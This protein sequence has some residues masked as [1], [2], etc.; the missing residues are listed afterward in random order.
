MM[1]DRSAAVLPRAAGEGNRAQR[2]AGGPAVHRRH[3]R[4]DSGSAILPRAAAEDGRG[5]L[6]IGASRA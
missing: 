6:V 2:G 3:R 4:V 5:G 1:V